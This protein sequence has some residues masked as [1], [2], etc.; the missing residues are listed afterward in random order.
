MPLEATVTK[1]QWTT[2]RTVWIDN[3]HTVPT[4]L[5]TQSA[6]MPYQHTASSPAIES[7]QVRGSLPSVKRRVCAHWSLHV[8]SSACTYIAVPYASVQ[9][10]IGVETRIFRT[11][12]I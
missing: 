12:Y 1:K 9:H 8:Q 5:Q 6:H 4:F 2:D 7:W 11:A 3:H 10:L